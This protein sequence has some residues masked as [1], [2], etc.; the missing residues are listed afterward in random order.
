M[1]R[2]SVVQ[3][4]AAVL[5]LQNKKECDIS[6]SIYPTVQGEHVLIK[7]KDRYHLPNIEELMLA[8]RAQQ[9]V[10]KALSALHGIVLV[11][12][13]AKS[14]VTTTLYAL[15]N[16]LNQP[17][18]NIVSVEDPIEA[19]IAGITQG[20]LREEADQSYEEYLHYAVHQRP[21]VL[22]IDHLPGGKRQLPHLASI[23]SGSLVISAL[24][25]TDT[26]SAV[27]KLRLLMSPEFITTHV[28]CITA[29][30]LVRTICES[31]KEEV[32][33]PE[34]HRQKLGFAPEDRCYAGKGCDV[35]EQTGY[36]DVTPIFEVMLINE[37]VKQAIRAARSVGDIR[38]LHVSNHVLSLRDDGMRKVKQGV[39]TV[40]EVLR[41]T[42]L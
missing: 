31:C 28:R 29:Q 40:Q 41:T 25:A 23:A 42:M 15:L 19:L 30:R 32:T 22:M 36:K 38:A 24:P 2:A 14:G 27:V 11:T 9:D 1:D 33:L 4:G 7:I 26:A 10:Q 35:C 34:A 8:E 39:T 5:K 6:Y 12:G 13:T 17:H 3:K 18:L 37:S 21:D 16:T 20:P